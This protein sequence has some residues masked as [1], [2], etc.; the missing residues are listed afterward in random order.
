[1]SEVTIEKTKDYLVVKIP[2]K[3]VSDGRAEL[4]ART[5]K[6][7]NSAI[8]EGLADIKAGRVYGPFESVKEFTNSLRIKKK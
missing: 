4:S 6:I 8:A 3:S 5:Q 1:M 7:I 2:L